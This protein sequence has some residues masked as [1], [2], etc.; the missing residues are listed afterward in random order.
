MRARQ[1]FGAV[2]LPVAALALLGLT[3]PSEAGYSITNLGALGG[4]YVSSDA[5]G[6]NDSGQVVGYSYGRVGQAHA[7]CTAT[8][9]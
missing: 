9:R 2:L 1:R 7:S 5:Q 8:A 6:I 3:S 4:D